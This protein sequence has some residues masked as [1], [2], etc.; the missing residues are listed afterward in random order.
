MSRA[1]DSGIFVNVTSLPSHNIP[2][3]SSFY[4]KVHVLINNCTRLLYIYIVLVIKTF[5]LDTDLSLHSRPSLY[6]SSAS[7]E[8]RT[9]FLQWI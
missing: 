1:K 8:C 3:C 7:K 5:M 2:N 9:D 6:K 4:H